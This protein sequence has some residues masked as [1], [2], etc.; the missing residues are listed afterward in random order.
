MLKTIQLIALSDACT[1]HFSDL[2]IKVKGFLNDTLNKE[3]DYYRDLLNA[4][5]QVSS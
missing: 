4:K 3:D 5:Y 2:G 1:I